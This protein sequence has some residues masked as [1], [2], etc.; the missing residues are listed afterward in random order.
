M[1]AYNKALT[2]IKVKST[3]ARNL[4]IVVQKMNCEFKTKHNA[5]HQIDQI[6]PYLVKL[7]Q[8][9]NHIIILKC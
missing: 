3:L 2:E 4:K 1:Y 6:N 9:T 8:N 5:N 7:I